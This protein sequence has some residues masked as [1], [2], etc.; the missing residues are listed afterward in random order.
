MKFN[1]KAFKH[2]KSLVM[3]SAV[4][5]LEIEDEISKKHPSWVRVVTLKKQ[6]LVIKDW[7][8]KLSRKNSP[9]NTVLAN[10]H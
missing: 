10:Q 6:R 1:V 4:I 8:A 9:N 7:L 2:F 3:K 5:Q